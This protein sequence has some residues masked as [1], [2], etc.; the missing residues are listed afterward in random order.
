[1]LSPR[2]NFLR[3][4]RRQGFEWT[5]IDYWL[6]DSKIHDFEIRFGHRDYKTFFEMDHR[7]VKILEK[8]GSPELKP[9]SVNHPYFDNEKLPES[10]EFDVWG[11]GHSKGSEAAYHMTRMHH[12]LKGITDA[13]LIARYPLPTFDSNENIQM[14]KDVERIHHNG[15]AVICDLQMTIWEISWY[16]R[17]MEELIIDIMMGD[18]IARI[19]LDRTTEY[20]CQKARFYAQ[21][22]VDILSLGDDIGT[23]AGPMIGMEM[24][25]EWLKPRHKKVIDAARDVNPDILIFYHSCGHYTPFIPGLLEIGVDILNPIQPECMDFN[26]VHELYGNKASFW[27][28]LGSQQLI[29]FGT[30]EQIREE[31]HNR[32]KTCGEKGGIVLG[33]SH[34]V[35]PEVPLDNLIAMRDAA[36]EINKRPVK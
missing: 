8:S 18:E 33:P 26:E 36:R 1:M 2:E 20:A 10:T 6:C 13:D 22:G 15:L 17:S 25:E 11:I 4:L 3:T 5:P 19:I 16:L 35:E 27:G 29:P 31:V 23:Q 12:P 24:W 9:G 14:V 7:W 32:I 30:K 21:A 28:T 34:L